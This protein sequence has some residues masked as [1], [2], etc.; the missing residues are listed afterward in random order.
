MLLVNNRNKQL[1]EKTPNQSL[2]ET[3]NKVNAMRRTGC[4]NFALNCIIIYNYINS[5]IY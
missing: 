3:E 4:F 1:E 2:D 5:G